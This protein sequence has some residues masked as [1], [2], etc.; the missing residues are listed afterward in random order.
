MLGKVCGENH[1]SVR[2]FVDLCGGGDG[3]FA[4]TDPARILATLEEQAPVVGLGVQA[5]LEQA[6]LN[7]CSF[8]GL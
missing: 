6:C 2:H 3:G 4:V 7:L 8:P 5:T 1:V